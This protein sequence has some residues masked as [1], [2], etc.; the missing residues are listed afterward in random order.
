GSSKPWTDDPGRARGH[1]RP[2]RPDQVTHRKGPAPKWER[3]LVRRSDRSGDGPDV[4]G[5]GALLALGEV[6]LDLLV[7]LQVPVARARDGAE[8]HEHVGAAVVLGDEAEPLLGVE[9]LHG[10]CAH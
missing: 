6:E 7:L 9:P 8:M 1:V 3:A 4:R 2:P 5:L 10:A